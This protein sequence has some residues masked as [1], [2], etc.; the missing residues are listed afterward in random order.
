MCTAFPKDLTLLLHAAVNQVTIYLDR[1]AVDMGLNDARDWLVLAVL[2]DG[3]QLT[4]LELSR[5]VCVDKTTLITVLDR[6]E[7]QGLVVRTVDPSDRRVRIPQI[8]DKG[9]EVYAT[10]AAARDAAE[11][12]ALDGVSAADRE[13]LLDVLATIAR[14]PEADAPTSS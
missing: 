5:V 6:L 11:A 4:Q 8:T 3:Q 10:F 2:D 9:R 13:L 1:A 14:G 12:R 7:K